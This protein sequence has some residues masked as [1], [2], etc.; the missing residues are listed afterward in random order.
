MKTGTGISVFAVAAC[1]AFAAV[2]EKKPFSVSDGGTAKG[3]KTHTLDGSPAVCE[4]VAAVEGRE[5]SLLPKGRKF[6]LVWN[7]E[8]DGDRLDDSK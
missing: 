3:G 4:S 6:K 5:A 1:V 8:F 2:A 7:D